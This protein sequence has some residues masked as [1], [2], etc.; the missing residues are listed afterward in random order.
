M[1][2]SHP[3]WEI[4]WR[5]N[6]KGQCSDEYHIFIRCSCS[7]YWT[8][9]HAFFITSCAVGRVSVVL[10]CFQAVGQI[11]QTFVSSAHCFSSTKCVT[12]ADLF[13]CPFEFILHVYLWLLLLKW[14]IRCIKTCLSPLLSQAVA[15]PSYYPTCPPSWTCSLTRSPPTP[16][17][18]S[19]WCCLWSASS[20]CWWGSEVT[21]SCGWF[22]CAIHGAVPSPARS[23][24]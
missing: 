24:C 4:G 9:Y 8:G 17:S 15:D 2:L 10:C 6:C 18:P 22:W 21:C 14:N 11:I 7:F 3:P 5:G 13:F 20:L 19:L 12:F 1:F 16:P 23:S